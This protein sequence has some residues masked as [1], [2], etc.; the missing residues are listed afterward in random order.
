MT[1]LMAG[2]RADVATSHFLLRNGTRAIPL[3]SSVQAIR[4]GERLQKITAVITRP[5]L[6]RLSTSRVHGLQISPLVNRTHRRKQPVVV[7][8]AI[9]AADGG[10]K[11]LWEVAPK[12]KEYPVGKALFIELS[13]A[14]RTVIKHQTSK[15]E[16]V[17]GLIQSL[18]FPLAQ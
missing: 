8:A 11:E 14:R 18:H 10:M 6:P 4:H 12:W 17:N 1:E 5:P 2:T 7:Q 16:D 9:T 13:H 3:P 15:E